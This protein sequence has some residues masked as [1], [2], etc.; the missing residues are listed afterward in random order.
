[1]EAIHKAYDKSF[2]K[3][4][5]IPEN[6]KDSIQTYFVDEYAKYQTWMDFDS[7]ASINKALISQKYQSF[8]AD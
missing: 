6:A 1:M 8:R 3:V 7:L 4:F 2:K 5:C